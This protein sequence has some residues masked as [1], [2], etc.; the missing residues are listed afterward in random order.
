MMVALPAV[1]VMSVYTY[2]VEAEHMS[3]PEHSRP[4]FVAY[5][6]L[7]RRTKVR[8]IAQDDFKLI[9][10]RQVELSL[11]FYFLGTCLP[12]TTERTIICF[13]FL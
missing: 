7:R 8:G 1:V 10:L 12:Y 4:P 11:F 2:I 5:E 9:V 3:H 13:L 6:Y